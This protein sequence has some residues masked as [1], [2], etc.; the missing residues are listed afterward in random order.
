M[1]RAGNPSNAA[2]LLKCTLFSTLEKSPSSVRWVQSCGLSV[3]GPRE[4]GIAFLGLFL[5]KR[6]F[7]ISSYQSSHM[8]TSILEFGVEKS[9][10]LGQRL[11]LF[12]QKYSK[13]SNIVKYFYN[14]RDLK[15]ISSFVLLYILKCHLFLWG[16]NWI[17]SIIIT[18]FCVTWSFRNHSNMLIAGFLLTVTVVLL[19]IYIFSIF[20]FIWNYYLT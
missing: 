13:N 17:F 12:D 2:C 9:I 1:K 7:A 3:A 19:N 15:P 4:S 11:H 18:V 5:R 16:Q 14:S 20:M 8:C 6:Q 10:L